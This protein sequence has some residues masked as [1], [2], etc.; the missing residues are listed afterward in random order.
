MT[1]D[2]LETTITYTSADASVH[3][4]T[5]RAP[6][7]RKLAKDPRFYCVRQGNYEDGTTW[8]EFTIPI[9]Q[10]NPIRGAKRASNLSDE[11]RQAAADRLR[12]ARSAA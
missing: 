5:C 11:Q 4:F 2:E 8:G 10:W 1:R 12:A 9:E 3:I 7:Y 6:D